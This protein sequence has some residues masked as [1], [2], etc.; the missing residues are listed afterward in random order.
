MHRQSELLTHTISLIV[1]KR[2]AYALN[3]VPFHSLWHRNPGRIPLRQQ[4]LFLM[5]DS[6]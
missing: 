2:I 5:W 6:A 3:S 4:T 1:K